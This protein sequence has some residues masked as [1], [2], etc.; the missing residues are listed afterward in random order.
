MPASRAAF[1][2]TV[3]NCLAA[4]RAGLP[5]ETCFSKVAGDGFLRQETPVRTA[6]CCVSFP[7]SNRLPGKKRNS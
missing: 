4:P 2:L 6:V 1:L 3:E 5:E 7:L